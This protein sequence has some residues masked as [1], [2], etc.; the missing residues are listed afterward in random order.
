MDFTCL[1][2]AALMFAAALGLVIGCD[3]LGVRK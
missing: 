1:A 2:A 3:N